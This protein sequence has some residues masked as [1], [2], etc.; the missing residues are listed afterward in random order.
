V[1]IDDDGSGSGTTWSDLYG[2]LFGS[3]GRASC[4]GTGTACHASPTSK[5]S[6]P[7]KFVCADETEC[8]ESMRGAANMVKDTDVAKPENSLLVAILRKRESDGSVQGTQPKSP[9]FVFH[10]DSIDRIK[11]WIAS[12]AE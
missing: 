3:S 12:G 8:R 6:V 11:A 7:T 1:Y 4:A 10:P 9:L 2:D 5:G